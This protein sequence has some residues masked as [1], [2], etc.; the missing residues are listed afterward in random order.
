MGLSALALLGGGLYLQLVE[1][2]LP[3]PLC[4]LQRYAFALI[5]IFCL[6]GV[7]MRRGA[8]GFLSACALLSAIAGVVIAG[9]HLW[10]KANPKSTCGIDPLETSLNTI[11]PA[12]LFPLM[13][14]ADGLCTMEYAPIWR[15][16]IPQWS[17]L[18]FL[19]FVIVLTIVFMRRR[20]VR[21]YRDK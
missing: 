15:L 21:E 3:C 7:V 10:I 14:K 13:F 8:H 4:V 12:E 9:R 1:K 17:M 20:Q 11:P 5:A 19:L 16:S 2:M 6:L 18:W